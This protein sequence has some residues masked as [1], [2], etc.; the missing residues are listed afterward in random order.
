[1]PTNVNVAF[2]GFRR[3][4]VDLDQGETVKARGSRDWLVDQIAAFPEADKAFP[5]PYEEMH[6]YYGSFHRR[7]K[8]RPLDDVDLISCLHAHGAS[9][10]DHQSDT[11]I[12]VPETATRLL[13]YCFDDT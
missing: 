3:D 12:T 8:I 7:T 10:L 11:R 9:Y 1:M 2:A 4:V 5:L 6:T 13:Q